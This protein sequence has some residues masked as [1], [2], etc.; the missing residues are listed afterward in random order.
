LPL[1]ELPHSFNPERGFVAT[2]NHKMIPPNYPYRVCYELAPGFRFRRVTAVL[3]A[4][5]SS[6][7]KLT[8]ADMEKLQNDVLSTPAVELIGLLRQAAGNSS[9]PDVRLLLGWNGLVARDS[10]A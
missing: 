4:A 7:H 8:V 2:A 10:A 6:G 3:E 9:D 5:K 1:A